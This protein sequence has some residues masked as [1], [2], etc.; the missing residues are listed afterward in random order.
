MYKRKN[1]N[2]ISFME[3]I[4]PALTLVG[5]LA[6]WQISCIVFGIKE[7]LL[8]S[9]LSIMRAILDNLSVLMTNLGVTAI[10]AVLGFIL[11]ASSGFLIALLFMHSKNSK[12]AFYPYMIAL[13]ATPLYALAPIFVIWFGNGMA[14]KIVMAGLVA[15]FPVLVSAVKGLSSS[16]QEGIDLFKSLGASK[17]QTFTKLK[18]PNSLRYVF[19]ALKV[20]TTMSVVGAVIAEFTGSSQGI[21]HLIVN[22]S[23]YLETSTMFAGIILISIFGVAFFYS[24]DYLEKRV[25]FWEKGE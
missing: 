17:W 4:L 2:A 22:S 15:F 25:V 6:V 5:I 20:A 16:E 12:R 1:I 23:Y 21:G 3:F 18:F 19:P 14:S 10:E 11:G 24:I 8:P 9:P 13:K 7:I